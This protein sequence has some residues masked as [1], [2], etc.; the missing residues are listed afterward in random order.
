MSW[1]ALAAEPGSAAV[2]RRRVREALAL[3]DASADASETGQLLVTELVTNAVLHA[4]TD[5]ELLVEVTGGTLR[6]EVSD[7][8]P[9]L[10]QMRRHARTAASGRGL[11]LVAE[12]AA[13]WGV[14]TRPEGKTVWFTLDVYEIIPTGQGEFELDPE[15]WQGV[16]AL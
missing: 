3:V 6:V 7:R 8:S 9:R 1:Q 14:D 4:R 2:A 5:V 12:L 15:W 10:P 16:D 13:E 11:R